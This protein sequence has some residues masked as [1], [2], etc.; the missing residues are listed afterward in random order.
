MPVIPA[1]VRQRQEVPKLKVSL[2]YMDPGSCEGA[3]WASG[4]LEHSQ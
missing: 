1:L 3:C 2:C 4:L